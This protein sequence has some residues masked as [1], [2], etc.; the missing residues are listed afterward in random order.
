VSQLRV[1]QLVRVVAFVNETKCPLLTVLFLFLL[2]FFP[3]GYFSPRRGYRRVPKFF[4]GFKQQKNKIWG[5]TKFD[6]L[7]VSCMKWRENGSE[8]PPNIFCRG[9]YK[10]GGSKFIHRV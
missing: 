9:E 8:S 5:E 3:P 7:G 6:F 2:S 10:F 4:M 1:E